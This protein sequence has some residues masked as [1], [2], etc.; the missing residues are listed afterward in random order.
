M[1]DSPTAMRQCDKTNHPMPGP[2]LRVLGMVVLIC[3]GSIPEF[4]GARAATGTTLKASYT[5][6]IGTVVIGHAHASSRF[7]GNAYRA[8]ISGST[9]GMSRIVTDATAKMSGT[10]SIA[11]DTVYPDNFTLETKER[12]L[13]THVE[14]AMERGRLT[15]LVA[16]PTLVEA[17]DRVP[18]TPRHTND[19]VDPVAALLVPLDAKGP[20]SGRAIC[21]RTIRVFDGWSRFDVALS[22]L[23]AKAVDGGRNTYAGRLVVCSARYIPVAGHRTS[24]STL[25][26]ILGEVEVWLAPVADTQFLVPYR[27]EVGTPWGDLV[28]HSTRFTV[29]TTQDRAALH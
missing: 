3:G 24:R 10:G 22:Y 27:F 23:G 9:G 12:G 5:I 8:E 28:V 29:E 1:R 25:D 20:V 14:M 11:G 7:S 26:D 21:D 4:G 2:L 16:M 15:S 18:V 6:S 13:E 19:V 17:P